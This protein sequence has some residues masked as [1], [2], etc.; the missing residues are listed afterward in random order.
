MEYLNLLVAVTRTPEYVGCDPTQR[1]TWLNLSA[2][3]AMVENGGV[4]EGCRSWKCRRCQQTLGVTRAEM[5][6]DCELWWFDGNDLHV[7]FYPVEQE[8]KVIAKR[9]VARTNGRKGGRPRK[10]EIGSDKE[11]HGKPKSV[12]T[13]EPISEPIS[14]PK[15]ESV[16]EGKVKEGNGI[17]TT[18]ARV[19]PPVHERLISAYAR[20]SFD[21]GALEAAAESLRRHAGTF[22]FD[23]IL[24]G[25]A[26]VTAAVKDWPEDERLTYLP[27]AANFFRDDL[28]RRHPSEW[29]S[30]RESR[31][32]LHGHPEIKVD[33]GGRRP[34]GIL[35]TSTTTP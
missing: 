17:T 23:Q 29:A 34:A 6:T 35:D 5:L 14:E 27:T 15:S 31:K 3:C 1:G 9:G 10:T 24:A 21:R 7:A 19:E 32:R 13:L 30:R 2:F 18:T 12:P 8:A 28:W 26:A 16:M 33:I 4:I 20:P 25:V 11:T 22:S